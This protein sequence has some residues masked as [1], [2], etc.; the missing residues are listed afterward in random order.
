MRPVDVKKH[1]YSRFPKLQ[2][3]KHPPYTQ[4]SKHLSAIKHSIKYTC[5]NKS[6]L[7]IASESRLFSL[8]NR[9][10]SKPW[11]KK[12]VERCFRD[13]LLT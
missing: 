3:R 5:I 6:I 10:C 7:T 13:I 9:T 1:T 8:E 12:I 11:M 2:F 4:V